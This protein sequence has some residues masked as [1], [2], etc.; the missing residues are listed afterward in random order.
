MIVE[1]AL[2]SRDNSFFFFSVLI[3]GLLPSNRKFGK[4]A[5]KI[6]KMNDSAKKNKKKL[7]R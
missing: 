4:I 5:S 1:H 6:V 3:S 7:P 2:V